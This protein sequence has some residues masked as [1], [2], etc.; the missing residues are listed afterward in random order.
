MQRT[1]IAVLTIFVLG[2][3]LLIVGGIALYQSQ[4]ESV[5]VQIEREL[6]SVAHLKIDQIAEW[7]QRRLREGEE[8]TARPLLMELLRQEL[9]TPA[10]G[11]DAILPAELRALQAHDE[12]ADVML[13]DTAGKILFSAT[14]SQGRV[15]QDGALALALQTNAPVLTDLHAGPSITTPHISTLA[16]ILDRDGA[17]LGALVLVTDVRQFLY[18][19]I[20]SWPVPNDTAETL[21]VR[22]EGDEVLFLNDLRHRADTAL[23]FRVPL[24][25]TE[26]AAVR[27]VQGEEG[28]VYAK[29]Y[30]G[31][32]IIAALRAVPDSP[33]FLV[34]KIDVAEVEAGWQGRAAMLALLLFGALGLLGSLA[35]IVL[36][37]Q[38]RRHVQQLYEAELA[39]HAEELRY[40]VTLHS[41]GEGVIATD[42]RGNITLLNPV[43]EALTGWPQ[44][45]ASGRPCNEVFTIID[46]ESLA[47]VANPVEVVLRERRIVALG[48]HTL[49]RDRHGAIRPIAD[50]ASPI[51]AAN[52]DMLGV[53][54]VFRDQSAERAAKRA[55]EQSEARLR[56]ML[57]A[58]PDLIF[59]I[60]H[61][62]RFL[63]FQVSDPA[64]LMVPPE[65]FLGKRTFEV[66]PT[67]IAEGGARAVD[68]ALSSGVMQVYEYTLD[69]PEG[70][71]WFEQR[72]API[73]ATEVIAI[74]RDVSD[75]RRNEAM[76][77][78]RLRL[79]E[80][81]NDH[82]L[83][84]LLTKTLD[85]VSALVNSPIGFY[86]FVEPDQR[87]LSLQA[88]STRT[89][90]EFC[91]AEGKELHDAI[92]RAGV[93]ADAVRQ[94]QPIIHDNY[95]SPPNHR[96]TPAGHVLLTRELVVPILRQDQ[97]VAVLGVGNKPAAYTASDVA[98]VS[99][100]ADVAWEIVQ[101]KRVEEAQA[102]KLETIGQLAGGVAHDFNNMLAVILMRSE[103]ALQEV[104]PASP[105]YRHLNEIHSTGQRSA[106]LTR[107]LLGFAR[108]QMIA[109]RVLDLN[110]VIA[111]M[112]RMLQRLIGENIDL[113]WLPGSALW[114]IKMDP[115]QI[116]QILVNLCVNARDAI[117]DT[118]VI[119][120]QTE[121]IQIDEGYAALHPPLMAGNYV[122]LTIADNGSGM[123]PEVLSHVFEPFFTTKEVGR[124]TGLGLAT[125]YGIV[126]QNH[127]HILV[128]SEQNFGTTFKLFFPSED[129]ASLDAAAL[130]RVETPR[131]HGE[132]VLVVEDELP[133]LEMSAESLRTLGYTVWTAATPAAALSLASA[134]P[135]AI[136]LLIT[137]VIMPEMNGSD[138]AQ[139]IAQ[140]QPGVKCLYMSGYPANFVTQRGVLETGVHF[141][142]KPFTL[143]Q[144]A[145][146]VRHALTGDQLSPA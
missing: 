112:L 38:R 29:D 105:L 30:R 22:R 69:L 57:A 91:T 86:H 73:S 39:R 124:G 138:L 21:L 127:G 46:E 74:T 70:R 26:I 131:G 83:S 34:A 119:K 102:Q 121:N 58:I 23:M 18:P 145:V 101:R 117:A 139:R 4:E 126:Q 64:R 55:L 11:D 114:P 141:I 87:T 84:D 3:A 65:Q 132:R 136:D 81:A 137:D 12:Y 33:W 8:I 15:E 115:S 78:A 61:E 128:Y 35:M 52:G 106:E 7:R 54:L 82:P 9:R 14:G 111:G 122:M 85:E 88:W 6:D 43:A 79:L 90:R 40:A 20:Q 134:Q 144:L 45:E 129:A 19:L 110:D 41:I 77:Q 89:L 135:D 48:N 59:R 118:G 120:I 109:P 103:M 17:P 113:Q 94:R 32:D 143:H 125:V 108:K 99:Y 49:L 42:A 47:P 107:K 16:P 96:G 140:S 53:V 130:L 98:L 93:W 60:D 2:L 31:K 25:A 24:S 63:D 51:L 100:L 123:S 75:I 142:S 95:V 92:D 71:A 37:Y 80:F 5:R 62:Y 13:V 72:I 97:V 36:Q 50:A 66:L 27:A 67:E 68:R 116:D 10:A 44:A 1:L 76:M 28:V 104:S 146:A 133:V 56:A